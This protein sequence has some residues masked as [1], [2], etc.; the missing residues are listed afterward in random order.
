MNKRILFLSNGHGEDLNGSLILQALRQQRPDLEMAAMP[1]VGEGNAYRRLDVAIIGPTQRLPSSGFNYISVTRF[2]NPVNWMRDLNF[3]NLMKDLGSG[4]ISLTWGQVRAVRRYSQTCDLLFATGDVVPILFAY[5]TG[6]PFMVFL[7]SSSSYYEGRTKLPL[8]ALLG[9]KSRRCLT[10]FTRDSHTA[11]DLYRRGL[12]KARFAGY[13]IMDVLTPTG[14]PLAI[15][16]GQRVIALLPGSR[17][18][19]AVHNLELQLQL[20]EFLNQRQPM[21]FLAA[22][23]KSITP[24]QL[25]IVARHQGWTLTDN[26]HLIKGSITVACHNDAF[27]DIL[28]HCDAAIG[29]AGTAVEQAVGLGKPVLQ[30]IGPGPQFTYP[31]AEAQMRLLGESVITIGQRIATPAVL[32]EAADKLLAILSDASYLERCRLNGEAR[33]GKPGG[34]AA[35]AQV[36]GEYL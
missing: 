36:L 32:A 18:P 10:I 20:C 23:V 16:P 6:R 21:Q 28:H 31:F 33:V 34:S 25:Q 30:I 19:E 1:I 14:K 17:L 11:E 2:L 13:P 35:I 8:L 3:I 4:L 9:L 7:V 27:P 29:M 5:I 26:L 24:E 15:K 12:T 22:L